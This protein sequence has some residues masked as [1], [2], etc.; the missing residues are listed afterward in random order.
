VFV[1][2]D[3]ADEARKLIEPHEE[4]AITDDLSDLEEEEGENTGVTTPPAP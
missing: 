1:E 4:Q 2:A 3:R